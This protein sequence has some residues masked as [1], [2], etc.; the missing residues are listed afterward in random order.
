LCKTTDKILLAVSGGMDSMVMLHLFHQSGLSVSVAH[1]NFQLRGN[2]SDEDE[3]FVEA[4]CKKLL[5]PFHSTR[6]HT[7]NYATQHGL[8]IQMAARELRYKWFE[9]L[10]ENENLD[11]VATAHH[12]TDSVETIVLNLTRG[13]SLD[14][15]LG[16]AEKK[17]YVIRPLLFATQSEIQLYAAEKGVSWREDESNRSDDYQRNFVRHHVIPRLKEINPS[18][19]STTEKTIEKLAGE[20]AI[21]CQALAAWKQQFLTIENEKF[22]FAKAGFDNS[23]GL[24]YN[25]ALLWKLLKQFGFQ[26]DQCKSMILALNGQPGKKFLSPNY[27]LFIDRQHLI[28]VTIKSELGSTTIELGQSTALMGRRRLTIAHSEEAIDAN[29]GKAMLDESLIHFPLTW[30]RWKPG[31]FFF[32]LGMKNQKKISDFLIDQKIAL[33]DK[34]SVTVLES[35]GQIAWVVGYRIDDRFKVTEKTNRVLAISLE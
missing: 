33:A 8:S 4:N 6:F 26:F 34:D 27:E 23:F 5:I 7:N 18:L 1:C 3:K 10:R 25:C 19:E 16:I 17:D 15:L 21:I 12:L 30:R 28:L 31:D 11:W 9:Q 22:F 13:T 14:G 32:P 2:E 24:S 29:A 20:A 35:A